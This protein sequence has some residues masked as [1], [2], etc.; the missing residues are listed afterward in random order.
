MASTDVADPSMSP[1]QAISIAG[2]ADRAGRSIWV[3][4]VLVAVFWALPN[5]EAAW[6]HDRIYD[7]CMIVQDDDHDWACETRLVALGE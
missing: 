3:V 4:M 1:V 5:N 6:W 2:Q 7:V